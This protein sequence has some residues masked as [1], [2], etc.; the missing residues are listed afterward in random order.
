MQFL[1]LRRENLSEGDLAIILDLLSSGSVI[2][3][4]GTKRGRAIWEL[5][6][7]LGQ[8]IGEENRAFVWEEK[9][10]RPS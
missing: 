7:R 1:N 3:G 8:M 2:A 10:N 6:Q 5:Y 4:F 9:D